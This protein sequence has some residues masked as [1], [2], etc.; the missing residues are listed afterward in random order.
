[1]SASRPQSS[2]STAGVKRSSINL[3]VSLEN[4]ADF[5]LV[6]SVD[7]MIR[8]GHVSGEKRPNPR[9]RKRRKNAY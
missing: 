5:S 4:F 1:M 3:S 7:D 6:D 2:L 8:L 9:A